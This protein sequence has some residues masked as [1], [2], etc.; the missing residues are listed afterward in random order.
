[1]RGITTA[2]EG[3]RFLEGGAEQ[4]HDP[5]LMD[6]MQAAV[7]RI[8]TALAERQKIRIYGDYDADGV[9]ATALMIRLM[10]ELNGDCDFYIPHRQTEGYGMNR[11]AVEL[12]RDEG[13]QL[14]ITVDT[15]ISAAEEVAYA[16]ELG[17]DV[18]VTDHHEPPEALPEAC[19]VINPKKPGCP[20]PFK[21]LAGVGVAFKLAHALLG[22][23]PE[24]LLEYAATGTI[25]DLMPLLGENRLIAKWGLERIRVT[26]LPGFRALI[27]VAG[28]EQREIGVGQIGFSVAPRIN[29][30]GRLERADSAV[31]CLTT[32]DGEEAERLA[33][34]LDRLNQE[35]QA[36]VEEIAAE[37]A[38]R[39]E[40][41][42]AA[43]LAEKVLVVA[44]ENWNVGV[45]GI[46]ASK[47]LERYYRP[48]LVFSVDPQTGI[49]KGSARSIPGFDIHKALTACAQW[50]DHFGGHQAAAGMTL[51]RDN[52]PSL[53]RAL[54]D[55]ADRELTDDQLLPEL[56][57]DMELK[58]EEVSLEV[59]DQLAALAPFGMGNPAPR[60]ILNDLAVK[61]IRKLGKDGRHLKL[62]LSSPADETFAI[63]A[64]G[65]GMADLAPH[66]SSTG[67]VD[68]FGE[69]SVN[70]WNGERRGQI[71]F[72]D[73]RIREVQVFDWRG[74]GAGDAAFKAWLEADPERIDSK[75][76]LIFRRRDGEWLLRET[77]PGGWRFPVWLADERGDVVPANEAAE[78]SAPSEALDLVL[79][80][81]PPDLQ[82]LEAALPHFAAV[83][84]L[85][86]V[87][88]DTA[89]FLSAP[90]PSREQCKRVYGL[91]LRAGTVEAERFVA[92]AARAGGLGADTV[93]LILA[94][95]EDLQLIERKAGRLAIVPAASKKDLAQ[96]AVLREKKHRDEVEQLLVYTTSQQLKKWM[97]ER[98]RPGQSHFALEASV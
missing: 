40:K 5:F 17:L 96:A 39:V 84:R 85:Y 15:G 59:I 13:V 83:E 62:S 9:C 72:K 80:A 61:E 95:F 31:I 35:R 54:N 75:A 71:V 48:A 76:L 4:F 50:L 36:I 27:E 24:Q 91:L 68:L 87:L 66:I 90:V 93:Q 19:A 21:E 1:M 52:L 74:R 97:V 32:D 73:I 60:F 49:A 86:G 92:S 12:A 79:Y 81:L 45:V 70:E 77:G 65:F 55:I 47:L 43:G 88:R 78:G 34:E 56:T 33:R 8:R 14:I 29:A 94:M 30:V 98:L 3:K 25:A 46:V 23:I 6:G 57:A 67:V 37:A 42:R 82:R 51:H 22:R 58:P 7:A 38:E 2:E 10:R 69:L 64:L 63:D 53:H 41:E 16:R 44:G 11:E 20:Y 28:L 89:P 26:G 18:I